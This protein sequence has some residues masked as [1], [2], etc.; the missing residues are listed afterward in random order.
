MQFVYNNSCN[1]T[2]Q[3]SSN[4][5][6]HEFDCKIHIDVADNVIERKISAAKNH[7]KKLHK[8]Q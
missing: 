3:M 6:L 1:H 7:I 5:L 2:I 8:L 4:Q